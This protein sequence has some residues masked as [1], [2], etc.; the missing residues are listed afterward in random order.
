VLRKP[1][2]EKTQYDIRSTQYEYMTIQFNCPRCNA[3]I[4]FDEKHCG[5]RA[6]CFTCG[7]LFII[8]FKDSEKPQKIKLK[9]EKSEPI[10]GFYRAVFVNSYKLFT[11]RENVTGLVFILT[12]VCFK[13]FMAH[14]NFTVTV[15]AARSVDIYV[16]LG[17]ISHT[18]AWGFLFWYYMEIIYSTAFELEKLPDVVMGGFY[19]FIWH[20]VKSIYIFIIALLVVE[21]PFLITAIISKIVKVELYMLKYMFLLGGLFLFPMA[22]LTVAIGRDLTMLKPNYLLTPIFRTFKPYLVTAVILGVAGVLQSQASQ[23]AGQGL[24]VATGHLLL[25]LAVQI[26]ALIAMRSIGLFY[27]HY[28]CYFRW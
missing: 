6:R 16:P 27:R 5:K 8:P 1:R 25:N 24:A 7:Q 17:Y 14:L 28:S 20:V 4:A 3:I 11:T 18:A 21:L 26:V 2:G 19:G 9:V 23:Y 15:S 12:A 22:I 13:F 10:T